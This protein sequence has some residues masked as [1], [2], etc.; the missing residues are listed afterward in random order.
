MSVRRILIVGAGLTG[1]TLAYR[2][3]GTGLAS[4]LLERAD[5]PAA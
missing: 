4:T 1:C 3:A 2:F 5:V